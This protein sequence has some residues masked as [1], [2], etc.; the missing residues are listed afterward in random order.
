L[1]IFNKNLS[2]I[3]GT[4]YE[5]GSSHMTISGL[6][7][8][9]ATGRDWND[10]FMDFKLNIQNL[11]NMTISNSTKYTRASSNNPWLAGGMDSSVKDY[12][13]FLYSLYSRLLLSNQSFTSMI[14]DH[15]VNVTTI[16]SPAEET[17]NEEWHYGL[18][19]WLECPQTNWSSPPCGVYNG[20]SS[21]ISYTISSPGA[22]GFYPWI[23]LDANY[24]G[25]VGTSSLVELIAR[26]IL[27]I[28]LFSLSVIMCCGA[29]IC[30]CCMRRQSQEQVIVM[31][32][33]PT[34]PPRPA[35]PHSS[36][37]VTSV[38]MSYN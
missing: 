35:Q 27:A 24:Y 8:E 15:T 36:H 38:A 10:I 6:M 18:G 1:K 4:V 21:N 28:I 23:N 32:V 31:G 19:C 2:G 11:T 13:V 37:G 20:N 30:C 5:Y 17:A 29:C 16:Y 14:T 7:V 3:P 22:F 9:N 34:S 25:I 12:N 33:I 26:I